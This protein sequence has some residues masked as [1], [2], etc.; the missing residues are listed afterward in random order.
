[1]AFTLEY[2]VSAPPEVVLRT[3]K[4]E[5]AYWRESLVPDELRSRGVYGVAAI[6]QTGSFQ[7]YCEHNRRPPPTWYQLR[8]SVER[9]SPSGTRIVAHGGLG[10]GFL[11]GPVLLAVLGFGVLLSGGSGAWLLF[12]MAALIGALYYG[13]HRAVTPES[14]P[15][16]RHVVQRLETA[17]ATLGAIE[18]QGTLSRRLTTR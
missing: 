3:I 7:L 8:G 14:D 9:M 1:M 18:E 15:G 10:R 5:A 12:G 16:V 6:I 2:Q 13:Y 11:A 4:Q 17:L